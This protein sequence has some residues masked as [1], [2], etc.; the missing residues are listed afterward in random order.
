[1]ELVPS[2]K[3]S[4]R[5]YF[6]WKN[7]NPLNWSVAEVKLFLACF[8]TIMLPVF[9]FIGLQPIPVDAT[10]LPQLSIPSINLETPVSTVE[11]VD[12]QLVAPAAIAGIYHAAENK[13]FIIGHSSSVFKNLQQVHLNGTFTFDQKT[14]QINDIQI[15]IKADISMKQILKAESEETVIIMTCAGDP[16]PNQDA[17]HRLIITAKA[18]Q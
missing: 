5:K 4:W 12:R 2:Q 10:S 7:L 3:H 18:L 6:S 14:Y 11:L 9:V 15:V 1:M 13:L 8:F 17:T 16:L